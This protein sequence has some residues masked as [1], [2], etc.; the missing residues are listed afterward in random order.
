MP[1]KVVPAFLS[2]L[3]TMVDHP[4]TDY[5][6]SWTEG[7]ASFVIKNQQQFTEALLPYYYKHSN[8]ASFIRQ[9]NMYGFK[10]V[11]SADSGGLKGE[12]EEQEFS[13]PLFIHGQEHL[14]ELIKRKASSTAS[15][16]YQEFRPGTERVNH[17]EKVN[18][19]L[20][21]VEYVKNRQTDMD[22]R[23]NIMKNE[24]D[25]L[26][27][28]V[29][30]LRLKYSQQQKTV[31]K[32]IHFLSAVVQPN[33]RKRLL[34]EIGGGQIALQDRSQEVKKIKL[35]EDN[36]TGGN[37]F[38]MG[39]TVSFQEVLGGNYHQEGGSE[40]LYHEVVQDDTP[41][42]EGQ[43][44]VVDGDKDLQTILINEQTSSNVG[45]ITKNL[46]IDMKNIEMDLDNQKD[47]LSGHILVDSNFE[48][49]LFNKDAD[50][51][52]VNLEECVADGSP[53]LSITGTDLPPGWP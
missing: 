1:S 3:W 30:N 28:E 36:L 46:N 26:W 24:N 34:P 9:L 25:A 41:E 33:G 16:N 35:G 2:K 8:M 21:E 42:N 50:F 4:D 32:L 15:R 39:E 52:T 40:I 6:I 29:M 47:D 5:L 14:L 22:G 19:L 12:K 53:L 10:K 49:N 27:G 38:E 31:N 51:S 7:G 43:V 48:S 23:I 37:P 13:H 18:Q 11:I 17:T 20:T 45:L 44:A